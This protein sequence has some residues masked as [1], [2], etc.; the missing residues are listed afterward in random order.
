MLE[1]LYMAQKARGADQLEVVLVSP[2]G[3]AK[4][5]KDYSLTMPW[6]SIWH[7]DNDEVGMKACMMALMEKF[8]VST[9]PA[10]VLLDKGGRV[11]FPEARGWVNADPKGTAFPWR[12]KTEAPMPGPWARAA[13]KFYL[14]PTKWPNLLV[15]T[16]RRQHANQTPRKFPGRKQNPVSAVHSAGWRNGRGE[17]LA[18]GPSPPARPMSRVNFDLPPAEQPNQPFS[19]EISFRQAKHP[20]ISLLREQQLHPRRPLPSCS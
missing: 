12:E 13:K 9:I 8:N 16:A 11:I 17:R 6:V 3:E 4:A 18:N 20:T 19:P 5:T 15:P 1:R 14:P 2:C 7:D 10:L